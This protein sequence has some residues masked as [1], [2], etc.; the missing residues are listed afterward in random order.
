MLRLIGQIGAT[1]LAAEGPDGLYLIDQHA[2]HERVL[3]EKLMA[4]HELKKIPSQSL[5]TPAVVTLP[6][7]TTQLLITQLPVL[8][9]FGFDVEEFGPNTFQVRAM[10]ALFAGSDPSSAL[11]AL[12]EDFEEDEAPLKDEVEKKLAARVCKRMAVRAGMSLSA[13]EQRALL[14][15]LAARG[16]DIASLML[17]S[18]MCLAYLVCLPLVNVSLWREL[19]G[20]LRG[21]RSATK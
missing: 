2:A 18:V 15:D 1:Y 3:F 13:D 5:L 7:Q 11:R 10:P 19:I 17:K 20:F 9:H 6:P 16:I 12:V 21:A 4:Q 8:N 14:T